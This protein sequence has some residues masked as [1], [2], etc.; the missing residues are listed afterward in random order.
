[1]ASEAEPILQ[2]GFRAIYDEHFN[3][4]WRSLRRLGI[5]PADVSDAV[6]EVFVVVH[7]RLHE[8][9]GRARLSTW[10]YRICLRVA[11]DRR[12]SA[13]VRREEPS[14]VERMDLPDSG[15]NS[16]QKMVDDEELALL[17]ASLGS[18]PFEQRAVFS[19]F[20]LERISCESIAG[21]LEIPLGTVYSRLRLAREAFRKAMLRGLARQNRMPAVRDQ[22]SVAS[23]GRS[24][25]E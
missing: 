13:Y 7:R 9:E 20:E 11:S 4:V 15:R 22:S 21:I 5:P 1:M 3:F 12:R 19:L 18:L 8:F 14:D 24:H 23:N 16:E 6:Q 10:L 17:E 25:H 2:A